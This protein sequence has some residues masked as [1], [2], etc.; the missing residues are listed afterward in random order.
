M[1]CE[2]ALLM[3]SGH[4]DQMNTPE[5]EAA[6]Q[7]HLSSCEACRAVLRAYEEVDNDLTSMQEKAPADLC[8]KVMAQIKKENRKKRFRPWVGIAVAAAL[9]LV[10]GVGAVMEEFDVI[11]FVEDELEAAPQTVSMVET[12][13]VGRSLPAPNGEE[14]AL[15]L[16]QDRNS[17][18]V[19]VH[20]L[21]SE[22]ETYDCETL[23]EGYLLYIL[24]DYDAAL[25]LS[26]TYGCV[27]Y[28]PEERAQMSYALLV[29]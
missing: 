16:A 29:P 20:E 23:D 4:L 28:E 15:Q 21:Y 6:L 27:I 12:K 26:E 13:S 5:E 17:N 19:L 24:P 22:I 2:E 11:D 25:F 1:K 8:G 3:I 14:V 18:V 10:I 9:T 7:A